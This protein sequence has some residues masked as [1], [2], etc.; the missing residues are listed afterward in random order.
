[1]GFACAQ[2][3]LRPPK[4]KLSPLPSISLILL[5]ALARLRGVF[6]RRS[7]GGAKVRRPRAGFVTPHSGGPG[8]PP[9]GHYEPCARSSL[10]TR[11][12]KAG[13]ARKRGPG[14]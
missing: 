8:T 6:R 14:T 12:A 10:D 3:I 7:V 9:Y 13:W 1:M 5:P 2:P 4:N 11:K